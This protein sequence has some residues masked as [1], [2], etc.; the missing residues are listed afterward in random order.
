MSIH[1]SS[2][3]SQDRETRRNLKQT[4]LVLSFLLLTVLFPRTAQCRATLGI[5]SSS[6]LRSSQDR[7]TS[8]STLLLDLDFKTQAAV[9]DSKFEGSFRT[10]LETPSALGGEVTEAYLASNPSWSGRN[11]VTA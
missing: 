7:V 4:A 2:P 9:L 1:L 11:R 3:I 8:S 5:D 6:F 10:F